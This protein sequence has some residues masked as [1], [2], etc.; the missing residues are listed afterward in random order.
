MVKPISKKKN[1]GLVNFVL[2]EKLPL[3]KSLMYT[4]AHTQTFGHLNIAKA[5]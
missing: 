4:Q 5:K 3:R 2:Q 1:P